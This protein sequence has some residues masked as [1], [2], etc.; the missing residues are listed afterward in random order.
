MAQILAFLVTWA[1]R[2]VSSK[3][4]IA[5]AAKVFAFSLFTTVLPT[6][7]VTIFQKIMEYSLDFAG[8]YSTNSAV[9]S[10]SVDLIGMGGYLANETALPAAFAIIISAVALR[11]VLNLI[12]L[13][14]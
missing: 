12:T 14:I 7:L 13:R 8:S 2:L 1:G 5:G 3:W 6:V 10:V 4:L 9:A 11:A